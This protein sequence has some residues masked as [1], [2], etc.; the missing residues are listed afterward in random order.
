MDA[1]FQ[2]QPHLVEKAII[3]DVS[4]RTTSPSL[5]KMGEIFAAMR[6]VSIPKNTNLPM[7]RNMADEQLKEAIPDTVTRNFILMNLCST[8][9]KT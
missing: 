7:A 1:T 8:A 4:P 6:R 5:K 3:V 9:D 2:F